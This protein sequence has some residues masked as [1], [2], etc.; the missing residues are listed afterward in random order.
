M[1]LGV[2]VGDGCADLHDRMMQ[3]LQVP[4]LELDEIWAYVGKKQRR[5]G[6]HP[7]FGDQ[8]TYLALD[9]TRKAIISYVTGKRNTATTQTFVNDLA[10]RVI[11]APQISSD[12]FEP[13]V[14]AIET[15]FGTRCQYGQIV[16][17]YR[18]EPSPQATRR[19]SPGYIVN[20]STNDVFGQVR[21]ISTSYVERSNLTLRM[22]SRRFTR[23]T[24]GFS[25]KLENHKAAVSLYVSHYNLCRVHEALRITPAMALGVTD[26]IWDIGELI[27]AATMQDAPEP[28]GTRVG[29]FRVIDGGKE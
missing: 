20:V 1:R 7:S 17:H 15:A 21:K 19:Y 10:E 29:P 25:K 22:Q 9:G 13:Y 3:D 6:A 27:E 16:K 23:L 4:T 18:A 8:Y 2:R 12:G 11:N 14:S 28:V 5:S 26:H 24:N